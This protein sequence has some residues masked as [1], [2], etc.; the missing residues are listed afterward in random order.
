MTRNG[1][2]A[3][4]LVGATTVIVWKNWIGMGLYEII[5][6]FILA[7][8]AIVIFSRIGQAPSQS[9]LSRFD[10]AEKEYKSA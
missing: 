1:A 8:L 6:G 4:M 7:T 10:E 9:M 2:L 3:G 5:P